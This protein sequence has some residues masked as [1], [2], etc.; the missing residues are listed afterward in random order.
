M[1]LYDKYSDKTLRAC[2]D[3][4]LD[5][6]KGETYLFRGESSLPNKSDKVYWG[7]DNYYWNPKSPILMPP[8]D[9]L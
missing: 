9:R 4:N 2:K 8:T 3:I 5:I 1:P 6:F 7:T